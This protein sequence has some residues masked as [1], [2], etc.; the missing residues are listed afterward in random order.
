MVMVRLRLFHMKLK[1]IGVQLINWPTLAFVTVTMKLHREQT[2]LLIPTKSL[3]SRATLNRFC[4]ERWSQR[5]RN[6]WDVLSCPHQYTTQ[7]ATLPMLT[8]YQ[9]LWQQS[10]RMCQSQAPVNSRT[11]WIASVNLTHSDRVTGSYALLLTSF[12]CNRSVLSWRLW[13]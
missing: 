7:L 12:I 2:L 8:S 10:T 11:I 1:S 9:H 6:I 5:S 4:R 3:L 13:N